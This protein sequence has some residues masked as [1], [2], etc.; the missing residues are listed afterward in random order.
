M[1][2]FIKMN[3]FC[4]KR[5]PVKGMKKQA[6]DGRKYLQITY[7]RKDYYWGYKKN[8]QNPIVEKQ[9]IQLE[10]GEKL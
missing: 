5:G 8:S 10:S 4:S 3:T 1:L 2:D 6:R 9:I 7:L